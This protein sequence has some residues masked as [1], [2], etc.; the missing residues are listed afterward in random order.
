MK[1]ILLALTTLIFVLAI[2]Q[3]ATAEPVKLAYNSDWPPY[4]SGVGK[5]VVGIL[6]D[7]MREI[8]EKRMGLS[9]VQSGSPWKRVQLQVKK[10]L[11]DAFVTVPTKTRLNYAHSSKSI[12]YSLE[13]RAIVKKDSIA[14]AS[15]KNDPGIE[16]FNKLRVCDILGNGFAKNFYGKH[17]IDFMTASNVRACLRMENIGRADVLIQPLAIANTAINSFGLEK[18][19]ITLP[20]IYAQMDFTLLVSKKSNL[21]IDFIKNFDAILTQ[22]KNDG[23]Y[24]ALLNR[25]RNK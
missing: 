17:R 24:D 5:D 7:V 2:S 22:M 11:S 1:K 20:K 18:V 21:G 25:L 12:V 19:L 15:L 4:S 13:M 6:P 16:T 10:G 9:V 3:T 14:H 8:M 23:S